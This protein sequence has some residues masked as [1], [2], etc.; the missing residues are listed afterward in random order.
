MLTVPSTDASC[1]WV[2]SSE[3][4]TAA[5]SVQL[6]NLQSGSSCVTEEQ[7][8]V[9]AADGATVGDDVGGKL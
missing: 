2:P 3:A 7:N 8:V 6:R 5:T 1:L 9:G 4:H